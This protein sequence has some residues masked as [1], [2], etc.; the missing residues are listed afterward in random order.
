[1]K[2]ISYSNFADWFNPSPVWKLVPQNGICH[3]S[4]SSIKLLIKMRSYSAEPIQ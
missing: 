2:S 4:Y 1:M 3:K